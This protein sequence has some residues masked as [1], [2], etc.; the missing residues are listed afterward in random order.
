MTCLQGLTRK[1]SVL[2][3]FGCGADDPFLGDYSKVGEVS[4]QV[5]GCLGGVFQR[6]TWAYGVGVP[7]VY[8]YIYTQKPEPWNY[9]HLHNSAL[10][11]KPVDCIR[12][13]PNDLNGSRI[14]NPPNPQKINFLASPY[15]FRVHSPG[16]THGFNTLTQRSN[17]SAR[18]EFRVR[19]ISAQC[20]RL[21]EKR[22]SGWM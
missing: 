4:S 2:S 16:N 10:E 14:P 18:A 11:A 19:K 20:F 5:S 3:L 22:K 8:A 6:C 21:A 12:W 13:I 15:L 1:F 9:L 17:P 7:R